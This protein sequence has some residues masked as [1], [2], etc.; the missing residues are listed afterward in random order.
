MG[1]FR[2]I[3]GS[4]GLNGED[5]LNERDRG[6][7]KDEFVSIGDVIIEGGNVATDDVC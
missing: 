4:E 3:R 1:E 7:F 2:R 5:A 6:I